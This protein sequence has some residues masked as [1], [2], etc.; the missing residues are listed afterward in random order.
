MT[1]SQKYRILDLIEQ[2]EKVDK[3]ILFHE[4]SPSKLMAEQYEYRKKL[5]FKELI[6]EIMKIDDLSKYSFKLISLAINKFYPELV[7]SS[8][9]KESKSIKI[10]KQ[11]KEF[12]E[13]EAV[14]VA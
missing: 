13:L 3:M 4:N 12:K 1:A 5:F 6:E 7:Q 2:I 8:A 11:L 9:G 14:L 10:N